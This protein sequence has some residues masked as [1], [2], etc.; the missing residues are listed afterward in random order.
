MSKPIELKTVKIFEPLKKKPSFV[1]L[2]GRPDN[3]IISG[4]P[5]KAEINIDI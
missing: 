3:N 4:R 5:D 1:E 2:S